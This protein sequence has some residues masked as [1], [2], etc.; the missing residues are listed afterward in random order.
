MAKTDQEITDALAAHFVAHG[1]SRPKAAVQAEM[2]FGVIAPLVREACA[3]EV[4]E[5][6]GRIRSEEWADRS[7]KRAVLTGMEIAR[8]VIAPRKPRRCTSD[9]CD[10]DDGIHCYGDGCALV[11]GH[12]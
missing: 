9:A 3:A 11:R 4:M 1:W 12:S 7:G 2:A 10:P 8:K 6:E 5:R